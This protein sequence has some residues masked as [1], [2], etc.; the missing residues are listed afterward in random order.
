MATEVIMPALGIAQDTGKVI[1]W[2][3]TEGD[4]VTEGEPLLEIETDKATVEIEAPASGVLANVTAG[5]GA[6]VPVGQTIATIVAE[7]EA[8]PAP[9]SP[10]PTTS[11]GGG[12]AVNVSASPV[13][14]RMAAD[15][16]LDLEKIASDGGR[17]TKDDVLAYLETESA[18]PTPR[19][20][21]ASPKARRLAN[22]R[23][24]DVAELEG[25]GPGG[26][27]LTADVL[28]AEEPAVQPAIEMEPAAAETMSV[29][30]VWRIMADRT[31]QSWTNVPH[32]YLLREATAGRLIDWRERVQQRAG[33][34]ITYTDLLVKLVGAA[35]H[36]HPHLNAQWSEKDAA[37]RQSTDVNVGLA[38]ATADGLVVPVI[39]Q[40]DTLGLRD[41]AAR[42]SELVERAQAGKL[43]PDDISGG[44]F[45]ISNLGMYGIDAFTAII[46]APESAILA[47]GR[48]ADRVVPVDGQP[49]VRP[50]M[51]LS[52]SCDHRVVDGARGAQFLKL[53]VELIE[54]PLSLLD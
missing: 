16:G 38:V 21:P 54:D 24:L 5:E 53:L 4:E 8:V 25:S 47:V 36:E 11:A 26:A 12:S 29:S 31:T 50:M 23:G 15:H 6:E 17:I 13:A 41:I 30:R 18:G 42:R 27:V 28:A 35:L 43:R 10:H 46:N 51:M 45:T 20:S 22:E 2:L 14:A 44:T 39:H 33:E 49:A 1:Q 37:I 9:A 34:N 3:K 40:A 32:F 52:L 7:G 19:L 48:I